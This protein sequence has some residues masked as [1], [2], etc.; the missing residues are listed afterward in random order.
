MILPSGIMSRHLSNSIVE[1]FN[2]AKADIGMSI[3]RLENHIGNAI[4]GLATSSFPAERRLEN[5]LLALKDSSELQD[6]R[7]QISMSLKAC[8]VEV[9]NVNNGILKFIQ[10]NVNLDDSQLAR[11][12]GIEE[13]QSNLSRVKKLM[14]QEKPQKGK[15]VLS[16]TKGN[17]F[18]L[19]KALR[20]LFVEF[21]SFQSR[22][23]LVGC[24]TVLVHQ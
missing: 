7:S 23:Q 14:P 19:L 2:K 16:G 15:T 13:K 10:L 3:K 22:G 20:I 21:F 9:C 8:K 4:N 1:K 11:R 5:F 24:L 17:Y 6:L 18:S 12:L